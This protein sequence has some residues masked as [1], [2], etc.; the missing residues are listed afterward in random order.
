MSCNL[1]YKTD[2]F[3]CNKG[4]MTEALTKAI[5][6]IFNIYDFHRIEAFVHPD[7]TPSIRLLEK[8]NFFYEGVAKE[9]IMLK[10]QWCD[11]LRYALIK[12]SE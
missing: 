6:I 10:G 11:H 12:P 5:D 1:S 3:N 8:F 9:Y 4:V 2:R 7:N